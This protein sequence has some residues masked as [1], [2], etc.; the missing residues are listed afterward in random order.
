VK[1]SYEIDR[2]WVRIWSYTFGLHEYTPEELDVLGRTYDATLLEL[3]DLFASLLDSLRQSG[4]LENTIVVLTA[5]HGE[6]LGE[7]HMLDHQY[8]LYEPLLRIPLLLYDPARVAPGR[9]DSPVTN[10]DLHDMLLALA[11]I[12]GDGEI[13]PAALLSPDSERVRVSE[14][15]MVFDR[16]FAA[17]R[18][19]SPGWTPDRW[20]RRLSAL[21]AGHYKLIVAD[22]GHR[23]LYDLSRD[24]LETKDLSRLDAARAERMATALAEIRAALPEPPS[25]GGAAP[26]LSA[27]QRELLEGL[28]YLAPDDAR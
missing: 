17:V 24:P 14:Y 15:P 23:E 21:F 2:S 3:D 19:A 25:A 10:L 9:D 27:E 12:A 4:Q 28:G 11:K 8:S 13:A 5:D 7:H 20:M 1:A 22:D 16:P 26:R 6:H 18:P